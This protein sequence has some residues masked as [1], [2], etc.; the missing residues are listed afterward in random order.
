VCYNSGKTI[1]RTI[2][3]IL[4]QTIKDYEYWIIDGGSTDNTLS[5]IESYKTQF[6]GKIFSISEQ[7]FGI[8][9]AMNKGIIRSNGKIIGIVNSDDWLESNALKLVYT[10]ILNAPSPYSSIYCGWMYFHYAN[11][12]ISV[13]KTSQKKLKSCY[14]K[15]D[16]GIRHPAT[17]VARE[18]YQQIGVFDENFKIMADQ[19]FIFRCIKNYIPFIFIDKP[20][21]N[22]SDGGVSNNK[23]F[24]KSLY[25][26]YKKFYL[27]YAD[28]RF[29]YC[30]RLYR[31]ILVINLKP[32]LSH[33]IL[34][35]LRAFR[36]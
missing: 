32:F 33:K 26:D 10:S 2:Q 13:L 1:S 30:K 11:G 5:I 31:S 20:L 36:N 12:D 18:V 34:Q 19:D 21:T 4:N 22:M 27:K 6:E 25:K 16:M 3:S 24:K 7:D 8:Y 23:E 28:T 17:F 9:N 29:E 35:I 14:K 15:C